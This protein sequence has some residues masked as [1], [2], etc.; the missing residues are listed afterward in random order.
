[1]M[2]KTRGKKLNTEGLFQAKN[3]FKIVE[4]GYKKSRKSALWQI[5]W[6]WMVKMK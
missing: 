2:K 4:N 6:S 5:K 3:A 1:M